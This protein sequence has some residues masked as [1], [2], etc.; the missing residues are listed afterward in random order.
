MRA[1]FALAGIA[2]LGLGGCAAASQG[3]RSQAVDFA[4]GDASSVRV[5]ETRV[6]GSHINPMVP[7]HLEAEG[8]GIAV[9]FGERGRLVVTRIDPASLDLLSREQNGRSQAPSAPSTNPTRVVLDD[10]RFLVCWTHENPDGGRQV[11]AQMWAANGSRL[12]APVVISPADADVFGAPHAVSTDGR[13]VVVTFAATSGES[14]ELRA[15]SLADADGSA[16]LD[17]MARR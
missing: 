4:Q 12:G 8:N 15:V 14:F 11:L 3:A 7:V 2:A 1:A 16:H 5:G 13:H 9:T 17:R 10:G 6:L